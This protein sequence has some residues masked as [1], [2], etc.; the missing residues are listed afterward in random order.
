MTLLY[1]CKNRFRKT[2]PIE[3]T[4]NPS[5]GSFDIGMAIG[6]GSMYACILSVVAL[7][8]W[9]YI[10]DCPKIIDHHKQRIYPN[11]KLPPAATV[12]EID[13]PSV[14]QLK[15]GQQAGMW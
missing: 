7:H 15:L 11:L 6:F 10:N 13:C 8:R 5:N 4:C 3:I 2:W 9:E 1:K 14:G 12:V